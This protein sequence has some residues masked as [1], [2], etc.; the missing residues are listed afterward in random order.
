MRVVPDD[1][2]GVAGFEHH[3]FKCSACN[4]VEQH[5]VFM[6]NGRESDP[7]PMPVIPKRV[8]P[9]S[10]VQ[11]KCCS[12]FLQARGCKDTQSPIHDGFAGRKPHTEQAASGKSIISTR[13]LKN[14]AHSRSVV[15]C[16]PPRLGRQRSCGHPVCSSSR[17]WLARRARSLRKSSGGP[18]SRP[19]CDGCAG[20]I[21]TVCLGFA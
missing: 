6:K 8:A 21:R 12:R 2:L 11:S 20:L 18:T 14:E 10:R 13:C 1:R 4:N 19:R 5:R 16:R 7:E 17:V 15:P 3:A 9:I